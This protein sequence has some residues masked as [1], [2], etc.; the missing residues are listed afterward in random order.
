MSNKL[1]DLIK[2]LWPI[3]RS[4]TGKGNRETL[5]QLKKVNPLLK[6]KKTKSNTKVYDW[7]IP[8]EWNVRS[9]FIKD[10]NKNTIIDFKNNN[11][12]LM[13]YS[14][15]FSGN[16]KFNKLIK[17][18]NYIKSNPKAI[19]YTTSY[20]KKRWAFNM[21]YIDFKKLKRDE[22]YFVNIDTEF[23][24]GNLN[25]GEIFLPGK[26]KKEI[27]FSTYICHPSLA[28]NELS[29]PAVSI[30]LSKWLSSKK[31]NY[32]YRFI[33]IPETI[34]SINYI[35][36]NFK[37]LKQNVI[38]IFNLTCVG[39]NYKT[40]FMPSK[41]GNTFADRV[42]IKT[43]K[44][45]GIKF[46]KYSW[47]E[48]GSDERQYMS[49]L[50]NIP[51]VSVMSSKYR[52]YKEYHTSDD[53]LNFISSEGLNKNL[54]IHKEIVNQIEKL[55]FPITKIICEPNLS[56]RNLYPSSSNV[57]KNNSKLKKLGKNINNFL[58]F[59]DGTNSIEDISTL[60][61][62]DLKKTK[63]INNLLKKKKI[64]Y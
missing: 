39:D 22:K 16:I 30:Y 14:T 51:T 32:S 2:L 23:K 10:K 40:S 3:N 62:L 31:T 45:K 1:F 49:A 7:K 47:L 19:P 9:A 6:I 36:K 54:S 34:G 13:G 60:I 5:E 59:A 25:Y 20:Y 53:N 55:E 64:I 58:S 17:K 27:L 63:Q 26:S 24:K 56:K 43:L 28:N 12:H 18:I 8:L 61:N 38:C 48:R 42:A 15:S 52:E 41:Y 29:G 50:V 35:K 44:K 33:F 57:S 37:N 4:L 46:T 21:S 11:L